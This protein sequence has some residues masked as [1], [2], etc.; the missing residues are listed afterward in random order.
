V[1]GS[2]AA[3]MAVELAAEVNA[4]V[5]PA[6]R[7]AQLLS[8]LLERGAHEVTQMPMLVRVEV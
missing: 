7:D 6:E 8:H 5:D 4:W 2:S 1:V 3:V